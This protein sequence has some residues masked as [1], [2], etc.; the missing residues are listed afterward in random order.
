MK[1]YTKEQIIKQ[2]I[3]SAVLAAIACVVML[4][5]GLWDLSGMPIGGLLIAI[6]MAMICLPISFMSLIYMN[7]KKAIIG[8]I[9]PIPI[10]SYWIE[11]FKGIFRAF[12]AIFSLIRGK[13][14]YTF[15]KYG[16]DES[17]YEE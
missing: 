9:A 15:N 13:D 17:E 4:V 2:L 3:I 12:G 5:S 10:L 6:P 11:A 16:V 1:T 14:L 7:W 8:F